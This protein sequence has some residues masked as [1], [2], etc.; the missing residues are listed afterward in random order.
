AERYGERILL[1][2]GATSWTYREAL[3][4]AARSAG[5]LTAAGLR[6]GDRVALLC[7][8]RAEFLEIFF[9][10]AW[11]GAIIVPINTASKGPQLQHVLANSGAW[12]LVI[13]QALLASL[14]HLDL[15]SLAL[16]KIWLIDGGGK[17]AI[18]HIVGETLPG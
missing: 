6:Q 16:E 13:E 8:N 1:R 11:L 7:G 12:L 15:A 3:A 10:C 18:H 17:T 14:D 5:R 2:A 9:G 4:I